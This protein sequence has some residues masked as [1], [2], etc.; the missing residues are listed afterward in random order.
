MIILPTMYFSLTVNY[1]ELNWNCVFYLSNLSGMHG[2][3][4]VKI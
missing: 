2:Q 1:I 4:N 3:Q